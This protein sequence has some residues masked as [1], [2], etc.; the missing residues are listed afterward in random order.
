[1]TVAHPYI[2][3]LKTYE[4]ASNRHDI[5]A[6]VALFTPDGVIV[7]GGDTYQGEKALRDAHEYDDASH[8]LVKF[9][10]FAIDDEN[11]LV[12]CAFWNEHQLSRVLENGG[13]NGS[14]EFTFQ[15]NKIQK[16]NI[17]PPDDA[18]RR[19]V[20]EKAAPAFQWLRENR[21]DAVAKWNGF[22]RAAGEAVTNLAEIW[23]NHL[24]D[25]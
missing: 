24:A 7:M 25:E 12:R 22:D 15:E 3:L 17:L 1:M 19:R 13:M 14:A 16:F 23:R 20:M 10:D 9:S 18:E 2:Q 6:C 8:T 11:N 4:Q 5:E 21:P